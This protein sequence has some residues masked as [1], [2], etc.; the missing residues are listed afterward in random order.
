MNAPKALQTRK[1]WHT[2]KYSI[3]RF[4]WIV[5]NRIILTAKHIYDSIRFARLKMY[6]FSKHRRTCRSQYV[7]VCVCDVHVHVLLSFSCV[8][9]QVNILK[10][11]RL[12]RS[13]WCMYLSATCVSFLS[14]RQAVLPGRLCCRAGKIPTFYSS[15][16]FPFKA[17]PSFRGQTFN[18]ASFAN[19]TTNKIVSNI[20]YRMAIEWLS[21]GYRMA[22]VFVLILKETIT[23]GC[24][25]PGNNWPNKIMY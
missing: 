6:S 16:F 2:T 13:A 5:R 19:S 25:L 11:C 1:G 20:C 7:R 4:F 15:S 8:T 14:C 9:G 12:D 21:N 10:F 17:W 18:T 23:D 24:F 22:L 3:T